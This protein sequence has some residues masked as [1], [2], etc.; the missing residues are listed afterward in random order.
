MH[1]S[2]FAANGTNLF[3]GNKCPSEISCVMNN[4]LKLFTD[5]LRARKISL[6]ESKTKLLIIRPRRKP[7]IT[8]PNIKLS[9]FILTLE[10]TVTYTGIEIYE[11]LSWNKQIEILAKKPSRANRILSKLR[12]YVSKIL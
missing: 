9:N 4:Q 6:G 1:S 2:H 12:Y 3:L 5:W 7:N 8:V 11:N 10:K